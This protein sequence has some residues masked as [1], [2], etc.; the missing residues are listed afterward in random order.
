MKHIRWQVLVALVGVAFLSVAVVSLAL[1]STTIERADYG[2]T[3]IEGIA[4]RPSTINPLF[5]QI[6]DVDRDIAALVFTGLTRVDDA[7]RIQPDLAK[8]WTIS[9]DGLVY[10][11]TLRSDVRWHD[12][13]EFNAADVLYTI[14][15]M[16]D[17]GFKGP[18]NLSTFWR[19]VAAMQV[20]DTTIRFQ[21]TQPYAPFLSYT[22]IGMLPAHILKD[23]PPGELLQNPFNRQPIGT[24]PFKVA[25]AS[26]DSLALDANKDFYG[27]QPYLARIQFK[28]YPDYESI[29]A[30]F[31][32]GEVEGIS[33]I[34]PAYL[35][36]ASALNN[37][38]LNNTRMAGYSLIYLNL[39]KTPFQ[40]K[41]VR[42]A[43]L[44][45]LDRQRLI[46]DFLHGQGTVAP[47][48][49]DPSSWAFDADLKTVPYDPE[50]AKALLDSAG[51]K[52]TNGDGLREKGAVV[53][54]FSLVTSDDPARV[55]LANEIAKEWQAVSV[56]VA[57]QPVPTSLLVQNVLRPRQFDAVLYDWRNLSSDPDQ[58]E[59]WHETQIPNANNLGQNYS[60]LSDRDISEVLEAAR[61]TTD[62]AKRTELYRQFQELF[63]DRVPALLLF[64]S[65]Y[66]YGV[67]T[68]VRGVQ[69]APMLTGSDRFRNVTQWY[70][71]TKRVMLS[72]SP[73]E[74]T[75][76]PTLPRATARPRPTQVVLVAAT[77]VPPTD[78]PPTAAA[79]APPTA[80]ATASPATTAS[81]AVTESPAA[82]GSPTAPPSPSAPTPT[83]AAQ[84][85]NPD[86]IITSPTMDST[87]SG[88]ADIRGTAARPNMTYWKLE[89]RPDTV[90]T[91]VQLYRSDQP[92]HNDVISYWSTKTVPNGI[93]WLQLTVVDNTGNFGS[94]CLIRVNIAN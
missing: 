30:A 89:Y 63:A 51:W 6:N 56:Q 20:D 24:G 80:S 12:G 86:A 91:F 83:L 10:T 85:S 55:A 92:I 71:K 17:P 43:L 32:R 79:T 68:R 45:A 16:Q 75:G 46:N 38:A 9:P 93:Y 52:D 33:R 78:A 22:T 2:G 42:Q 15:A 3:Y 72:M 74:A 58:Y 87:V 59:N 41:L 61:K 49:I 35:E 26:A 90:P 53:F 65:V 47:G 62:P 21:L 19:T 54:A 81:P 27:T 50:K 7:G 1:R 57:V 73:E 34:Q 39:S 40:D 66:T 8:E 37:L 76:A 82:T 31:A 67:D 70:L 5:S 13:V 29:F 44:Y 69:L 36:K 88:L 28:F 84:C 25:E 23:V 18:P 94:P 4:G 48:P 60:G 64:N 11:F 77:P 14:N